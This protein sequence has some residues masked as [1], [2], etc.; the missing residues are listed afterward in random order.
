MIP[1]MSLRA[2]APPVALAKPTI[3]FSNVTPA[4]RKAE[5]RPR[6]FFDVPP[7]PPSSVSSRR[8]PLERMASSRPFPAIERRGQCD[9]ATSGR[10]NDEVARI[11]LA[12]EHEGAGCD[13]HAETGPQRDCAA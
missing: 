12:V 8:R 1:A 9:R 7:T 13:R 2:K 6:A 3:G 11:F 10:V 5:T 4:K